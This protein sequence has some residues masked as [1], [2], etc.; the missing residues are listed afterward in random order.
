[1]VDLRRPM[2]R[3]IRNTTATDTT[4]TA[5]PMARA[6]DLASWASSVTPPVR[7]RELGLDLVP[8]DL[9]VGRG[10]ACSLSDGV[11]GVWPRPTALT[12]RKAMKTTTTMQIT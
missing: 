6:W 1:M 12:A 8:G 10:H 4:T 3:P 11:F 5:S 9:L 7:S 2:R